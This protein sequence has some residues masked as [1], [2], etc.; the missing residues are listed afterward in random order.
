MDVTV[1]STMQPATI[2]GAAITQGHWLK[3]GETQV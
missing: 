1:I 3:R 2:Q